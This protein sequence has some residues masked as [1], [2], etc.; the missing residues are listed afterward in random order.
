[1]VWP[2]KSTKLAFLPN[3]L[4]ISSKLPEAII[5]SFSITIASTSEK[6][7]LTTESNSGNNEKWETVNGTTYYIHE[8]ISSSIIT[9]DDGNDGI[10]GNQNDTILWTSLSDGIPANGT[11]YVGFKAT[12]EASVPSEISQAFTTSSSHTESGDSVSYVVEVENNTV[13][14]VDD[15]YVT[16]SIPENLAVTRLYST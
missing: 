8:P 13:F 12:L 9:E 2:F 5:F 16:I 15:Y 14:S 7:F 4:F 6:Y 3:L 10:I 11:V 1:M